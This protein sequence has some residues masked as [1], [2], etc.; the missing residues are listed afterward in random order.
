MA[1]SIH[2]PIEG[3]SKDSYYISGYFG[4]CSYRFQFFDYHITT[5]DFYDTLG[6]MTV[7]ITQLPVDARSPLEAVNDW[8]M[9]QRED[10]LIGEGGS[11]VIRRMRALGPH[12]PGANSNNGA[13][14]GTTDGRSSSTA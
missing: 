5:N 12:G 14:R 13:R 8:T 11:D 1:R 10:T 4:L 7:Q 2:A 6:H 3:S 9:I